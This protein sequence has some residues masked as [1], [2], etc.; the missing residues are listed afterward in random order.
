MS[1]PS[2]ITSIIS[3]ILAAQPDAYG[4]LFESCEE[5][6]TSLLEI[7]G[8]D[9]NEE[10]NRE[11]LP[12]QT[13]EAIGPTW[14]AMCIRDLMRTKKFIDGIYQATVHKLQY[15]SGWPIHILYAGTGPFATL[16]LPLIA[17][18]NHKEIQLTLIE[19]NEKSFHCLKKL[20]K[21]LQIEKYIHHLENA[22]ATEW[23]LPLNQSVDI[24]ICE[25]IQQGLRTEPQ[26]AI[27]LNILPQLQPDT[28][29]IPEKVELSAA[30]MNIQQRMKDKLELNA[31]N[32]AIHILEPV[33]T[34][35][36]EFIHAYSKQFHESK[37]SSFHFQATITSIP[38][39][40]AECHPTLC[41]LTDIVIYKHH[42][43]LID[44]SPLTLP[45]TLMD[46]SQDPSREIN[47]QYGI[48]RNP[49]LRFTMHS[50]QSPISISF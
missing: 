40:V 46:L 1:V 37:E 12:L 9:S 18:F 32:P 50:Q 47:F 28:I 49:G 23:K 29:L 2:Q 35:N 13:G 4:E 21:S 33:F 27:C 26:V 8:F 25:A 22:D 24:F 17:K 15:T 41:I 44:E 48:G 11:N 6:Y 39:K 42:R 43:L 36:K 31:S 5:L 16:G 34:L 7:T 30:L 10:K 3:R 38:L 14:A 45:M 20:I 19:V